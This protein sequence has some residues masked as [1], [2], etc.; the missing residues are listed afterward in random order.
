MAKLVRN[1]Q[2]VC[3]A[4]RDAGRGK[5]NEL[6]KVNNRLTTVESRCMNL[7]PRTTNWVPH[8]CYLSDCVCVFVWWL[9]CQSYTSV[10]QNISSTSDE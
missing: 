5:Y 2:S 6:V 8:P 3:Q 7:N 10:Y 9:R 4:I 1:L